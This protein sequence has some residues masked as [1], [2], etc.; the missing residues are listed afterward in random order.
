MILTT[1]SKS[2]LS[3]SIS[4]PP[5]TATRPA[6]STFVSTLSY[7][8]KNALRYAAGYIPRALKKKLDR[9]SHQHKA[10][11]LFCLMEQAED[12]EESLHE[13]KDWEK[14]IDQGG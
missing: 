4:F 9:S 8:E 1:T 14:V 3:L 11:L 10:E 5:S 7:E 12:E 6:D 13:S 2:P